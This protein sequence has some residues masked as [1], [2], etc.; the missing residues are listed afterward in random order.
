MLHRQSKT[1]VKTPWFDDAGFRRESKRAYRKSYPRG[2]EPWAVAEDRQLEKT[3]RKI[4]A[5]PRSQR[6]KAWTRLAKRL[7][8]TVEAVKSR[9]AVL[10]AA[11]R[12][13]SGKEP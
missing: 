13:I 10:A 11:R 1:G 8:R 7:G 9:M 3:Q 4:S 12:L 6:Y 2:G 5:L